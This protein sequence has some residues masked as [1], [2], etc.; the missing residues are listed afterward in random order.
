MPTATLRIKKEFLD[1][2][3]TLVENQDI[4]RSDFFGAAVNM[5]LENPKLAE[6][7]PHIFTV[8]EDALRSA[9]KDGLE[10]N[11]VRTLLGSKGLTEVRTVIEIGSLSIDISKDTVIR[12]KPPNTIEFEPMGDFR[13]QLDLV[14]GINIQIYAAGNKQHLSEDR[15]KELGKRYALYF[16]SGK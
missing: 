9:L 13:I 8:D 15:I 2:I 16:E 14:S 11:A 4:N 1:K 6:K 7:D 5:L 12:F 10:F 3:D